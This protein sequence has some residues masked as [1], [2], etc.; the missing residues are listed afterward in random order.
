MFYY[1]IRNVYKE[2]LQKVQEVQG[3]LSLHADQA[4]RQYHEIQPYPED[5]RA[6]QNPAELEFK[7]PVLLRILS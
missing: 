1:F 3:S 4:N 7:S 6:L 5:L 2:Q